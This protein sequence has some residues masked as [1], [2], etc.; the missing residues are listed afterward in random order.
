MTSGRLLQPFRKENAADIVVTRS[1]S[2]P[3][4]YTSGGFVV[5]IS[6]L[7]KIKDCIVQLRNQ[8]NDKRIKYSFSGNTVTIQVFTIV[9]DTSTGAISASEVTDGTDLSGLTFDIIVVGE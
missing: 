8:D 9:A 6:E 1:V 2:G 5:T 4:S 7:T 3:S